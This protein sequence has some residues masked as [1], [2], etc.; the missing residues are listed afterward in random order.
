MER[1]SEAQHG[2]CLRVD[3]ALTALLFPRTRN[4]YATRRATHPQNQVVQ[5]GDG[6]TRPRAEEQN[7]EKGL[8]IK[9]FPLV[10]AASHGALS[11][12]FVRK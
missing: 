12:R 7:E 2:Q 6:G 3:P 9:F 10:R 4:T 8:S 5:R 11:C 1:L